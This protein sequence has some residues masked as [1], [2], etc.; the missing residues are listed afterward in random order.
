MRDAFLEGYQSGIESEC[1]V[2]GGAWWVDTK[3]HKAM[4]KI[5]VTSDKTFNRLFD[6]IKNV[7][8]QHEQGRSGYL[9]ICECGNGDINQLIEEIKIRCKE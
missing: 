2:G 6:E 4:E 8:W 3:S 9:S 1:I 5:I 7:N